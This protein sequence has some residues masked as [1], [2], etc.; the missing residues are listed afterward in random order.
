M[1]RLIVEQLDVNTTQAWEDVKNN[2]DVKLFLSLKRLESRVEEIMPKI[3]HW[4]RQDPA[5]LKLMVEGDNF[6]IANT[7]ALNFHFIKLDLCREILN[8]IFEDKH[9]RHVNYAVLLD[10]YQPKSEEWLKQAQY[11]YRHPVSGHL[12]NLETDQVLSGDSVNMITIFSVLPIKGMKDT[13]YIT[14][15]PSIVEWHEKANCDIPN[16]RIRSMDLHDYGLAELILQPSFRNCVKLGANMIKANKNVFAVNPF[17]QSHII[18]KK[19]NQYLDPLID[20]CDI[21]LKVRSNMKYEIKDEWYEF[22]GVPDRSN[23][24][25]FKIPANTDFDFHHLGLALEKTYTVIV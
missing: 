17:G 22:T 5:K 15:N 18:T 6:V 8:S 20:P 25:Q 12:I 14:F 4:V 10:K 23:Y 11:Y 24:I 21:T 16:W 9:V 2:T 3:N 19:K 1:N 7:Q 13:Y